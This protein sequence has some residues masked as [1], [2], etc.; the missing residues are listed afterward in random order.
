MLFR[1]VAS[2]ADGGTIFSN[3]TITGGNTGG[4]FGINSSTGAISVVNNTN[5]DYETLAAYSLTVTVSDGLNT[6]LVQAVSVNITPV[7]DNAPIITSNG[8][9]ATAA[10]N[11]AENTIAVT[12]V[13]ATDADLPADTLA[14]SI[15]GGLDAAKFNINSSSG[16]LSFL[17]APNYEA[18]T[19]NGLNN[20]YNVTIQVSDGTL[21]DS[22]EI[23]VTV[24][25]V[26]PQFIGQ[27]T[28]TGGSSNGFGSQASTTTT[29][30][31][32]LISTASN[33][34]SSGTSTIVNPGTTNSTSTTATTNTAASSNVVLTSNNLVF[35]VSVSPAE[36]TDHKYDEVYGILPANAPDNIVR[37][38]GA[39]VTTNSTDSNRFTG[40]ELMRRTYGVTERYDYDRVFSQST[41]NEELTQLNTQRESL[42]R[43]LSERVVEQSDSVA[44]QLKNSTHFKGRI[45]GSVGVVTTG[46]SVGYLFW[47]IRGGMLVSGLLAQ[48]P[49][50]TML[51]PL[52]VIDG[53]QKDEDKESLQNLMDRQ[54]AKM[55]SNEDTAD[56]PVTSD[57]KTEA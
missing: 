21:I 30:T 53:D 48:V 20:V 26:I 6:S 28:G 4:V 34:Q 54:Q 46:F 11:V 37:F 3:W 2:D 25:N 40:T 36:T 56:S 50:W 14:Y 38:G 33:S 8:G 49:A 23:A 57:D 7:N 45:V 42:Y 39:T 5:L 1:S 10:V 22:Q 19:D 12:T 18:P 29:T 17:T 9:G 51:D 32:S 43:Q 24:I 31:N 16:V 55:K 52:L 27:S 35:G 13:T 15:G 41:S 47:A 44:E